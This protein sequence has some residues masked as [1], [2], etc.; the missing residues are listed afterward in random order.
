MRIDRL[1]AITIILLNQDKVTAKKLAKKFEVSVRTI[2]RD[3]DVISLAGIPIISYSGNNG[4]F[5]LVEDYK[6]DRQFLSPT[7]IG[8]ILSAL[9]S[10]NRT[11]E[12]KELDLAINKIKT[13]IPKDKT[14]DIELHFEQIVVDMLPWG[15]VRRKQDKLKD[16]RAAVV[17]NSL[18]SFEY[19]NSKEEISCRTIEPMTLLFRGYAWYLFG[20]CYLKNDYRLFRLS[21]IKNLITEE[22]KFVRREKTFS[23]F[24]QGI[25]NDLNLVELVLRFSPKVRVKVEDYFEE[26]QISVQKNGDLI[27]KISF[28]E[29]EWVYS[30]ILSYGEHVEVL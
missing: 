1:L 22:Q 13:L 14:K 10:V 7:D 6:I 5:G 17:S 15:Y 21:R 18:I 28:P 26:D 20:Y 16:I 24:S 12:T 8:T 30:Y 3:I 11:L 19:R 23:D 2:Y 27:V 9:K 29:D 25:K 4:G